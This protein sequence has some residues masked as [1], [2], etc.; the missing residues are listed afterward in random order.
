MPLQNAFFPPTGH[1]I[2]K[3]P[4]GRVRWGR[5]IA[6]AT[7][8]GVWALGTTV[9]VD[10]QDLPVVKSRSAGVKH[11][12]RYIFKGLARMPSSVNQTFAPQIASVPCKIRHHV[13]S[14]ALL[15]SRKQAGIPLTTSGLTQYMHVCAHVQCSNDLR[16]HPYLLEDLLIDTAKDLFQ[17]ASNLSI[18]PRLSIRLHSQV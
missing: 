9:S 7:R 6:I 3:H 16:R 12:H 4:E 2:M 10:P 18:W 17:I 5:P 13:T 8:H 15:C 1:L 11:F 14:P